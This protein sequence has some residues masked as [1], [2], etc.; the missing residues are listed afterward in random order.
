MRN[1]QKRG[2]SEQHLRQMVRVL[3]LPSELQTMLVSDQVSM[4]VAL[5]EYMYSGEDAVDNI[6]KAISIYGKATKNT[7]KFVKAAKV[8]ERMADPQ[9]RKTSVL[10]NRQMILPITPRYRIN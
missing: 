2:K 5:D 1:W 3:D 9:T 8:E 7:L 4:Y 10:S 6:N